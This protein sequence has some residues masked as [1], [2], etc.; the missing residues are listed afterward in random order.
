V[1]LAA[2]PLAA[3]CRNIS[4]FSTGS[5]SYQG[6]VVPAS[7]VLAGIANDVNLCLTLDTDHLQDGPGAVSTSDGMFEATPL[8]PIPQIWQDPLSTLNFGEGR[9]KNMVY[10]AAPEP[11]AG[12]PT[13]VT[14]VI[15]LLDSGNVEVRLVRGAPTI[16]PDGGSANGASIF[17]VFTLQKQPTACP[18]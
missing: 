6:P 18:F 11:D 5:G 13:D 7:F 4:G 8:R 16:S 15:S 17:A 3:G 10:M 14:V 9:L 1:L 12:N 2:L